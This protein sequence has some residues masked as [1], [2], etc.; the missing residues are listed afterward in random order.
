MTPVYFKPTAQGLHDF[1]AVV[2][3]AA[4]ELPLWYYHFPDRTGVQGG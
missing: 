3:A 1:L 4:P 2:G